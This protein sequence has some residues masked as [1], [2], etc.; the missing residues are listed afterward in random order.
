MQPTKKHL[1]VLRRMASHEENGRPR[2]YKPADAEECEDHGWLEA[3]PGGGYLLTP[4]G[5]RIL[6]SES[7]G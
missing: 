5:R 2:F 3:Q 1:K 6:E 4:E 7:Q